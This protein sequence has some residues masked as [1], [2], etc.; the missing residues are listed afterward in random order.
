MDLKQ[1]QRDPA[2]FRRALLIDRDGKP[3]PF[4]AIMDDWQDWDFRVLDDGWKRVA[5]QGGDGT[6]RAYLERP[7]GHSKTADLAVAVNAD[8]VKFGSLSRGERVTKYN[9]LMEI[10]LRR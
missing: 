8:F 9:R 7:R 6:L 4:A 1:L 2:A 5:G 10:E 3:T